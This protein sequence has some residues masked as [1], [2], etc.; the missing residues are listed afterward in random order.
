MFRQ[1]ERL[2]INV[3]WMLR[4]QRRH[5]CRE[6]LGDRSNEFF[7]GRLAVGLDV[8]G[9]RPDRDVSPHADAEYS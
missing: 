1:E 7:I 4:H 8:G 6:A 5:K 9:G 3:F 2:E